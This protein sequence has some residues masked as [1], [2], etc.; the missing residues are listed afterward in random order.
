L[1]PN[2]QACFLAS[3]LIGDSAAFAYFARPFFL[4]NV[5]YTFSACSITSPYPLK[6]RCF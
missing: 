5:P 1:S 6:K 4:F 2:R 3:A